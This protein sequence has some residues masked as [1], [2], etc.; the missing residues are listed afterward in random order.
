MIRFGP[1]FPIVLRYLGVFL[2]GK[3]ANRDF[4]M[5]DLDRLDILALDRGGH[6]ASSTI[7]TAE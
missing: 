4:R 6:D 1:E 3:G 5:S 7:S 2:I